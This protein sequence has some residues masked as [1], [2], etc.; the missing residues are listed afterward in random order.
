MSDILGL[1]VKVATKYKQYA[2]TDDW[3]YVGVFGKGGGGEFPIDFEH[4][5]DFE[6]GDKA[7]YY[8]GEVW[9]GEAI[10]TTYAIKLGTGLA[11]VTEP[12]KRYIDLELVDYV[13]VRKQSIKPRHEDDEWM[14][15]SIEV[16]LYGAEP[17]KRV[18]HKTGD[19]WLENSNGLQVWLKEKFPVF[20]ATPLSGDL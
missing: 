12:K 6:S 16:S 7:T 18:F 3:I 4:G 1:V 2:G 8:L 10:T 15:D 5:D 20:L 13:Y 9:E 11:T 17:K 19:I 14:L